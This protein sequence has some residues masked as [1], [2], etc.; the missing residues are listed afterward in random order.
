MRLFQTLLAA[1]ALASAVSTAPAALA[2]RASGQSGAAIVVDTGRLIQT[3]DVG[4]DMTSK[5]QAIY[6]QMQGEVQPEATAIGAEEQAIQTAAHGLTGAQVAANPTLTARINALQQREQTFQNRLDTLRADFSFTQQ[7]TIQSFTTQIT[8]I[9]REVM[10]GRGAAVAVSAQAV[11]AASPT[12]DATD[13][14]IAR[15]N[16]RLRTITVTRQSAPAEQGPAPAGA[17]AAPAPPAG[18]H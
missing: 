2:Q 9:V 5:L 6:Q 10:E 15:L 11:I 12:V 1:V 17:A 8:P 18:R 3:S 13:D 16:Q 14:V 7:V 4:R